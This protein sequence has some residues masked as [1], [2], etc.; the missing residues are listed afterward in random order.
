MEDYAYIAQVIHLPQDYAFH[1]DS[2]QD[3]II[4]EV[5][6]SRLHY[7][8]KDI[9]QHQEQLRAN[10]ELLTK[11]FVA[12]REHLGPAITADDWYAHATVDV[13]EAWNLSVSTG[14]VELARAYDLIEQGKS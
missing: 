1:D 9:L 2:M 7:D 8:Q 12:A 11:D 6:A 10:L 14:V 13:L 3:V 4:D 5:L